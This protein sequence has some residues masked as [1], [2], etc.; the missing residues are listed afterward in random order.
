MRQ[1]NKTSI[2]L[3]TLAFIFNHNVYA[4]LSASDTTH[5][6]T[7][8]FPE[9]KSGAVLMKSGELES[10]EL[11][12]NGYDQ[13]IVYKQGGKVYTLTGIET[14]DTVYFIGRKY[15]PVGKSFYEI[16]ESG[17][18]VSLLVT[19]DA[20]IKPISA[21]VEHNGA[22][23]KSTSEVMNNITSTNVSRSRYQNGYEVEL[24]QVFWLLRFKHIYRTN[25]EK[26]TIR[27]FPSHLTEKLKQ[28]FSENKV[29]LKDPE[30]LVNL[31][32]FAN[33]Q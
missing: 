21:T 27:A 17:E 22:T 20:K 19:Y 32:K 4:Q 25:N 8:L 16:V 31:I 23:R 9:F 33:Q 15:I 13:Q 5:T 14:V 3:C 24:K 30:Q 18:P 11:N 26:N 28:Y 10:A 29:D 6:D 7:Y 2:L 12:Y 1:V